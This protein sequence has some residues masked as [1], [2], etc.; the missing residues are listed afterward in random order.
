MEKQ[1][2]DIELIDA[3]LIGSLNEKEFISFEQQLSNDPELQRRVDTQKT[4]VTELKVNAFNDDVKSYL[5][6]NK[7]TK[8]IQF[9][10]WRLIGIAASV[11]ILISTVYLL[12][13]KES[14]SD[15]YYE[16][17]PDLISTRAPTQNSD[18]MF[19][20]NKK[21]YET[22]IGLF[23]KQD[24]LTDSENFYLG[25]S[26]LSVEK[27]DQAEIIFTKLL[28]TER[29]PLAQWYLSLSYIKSGEESKAVQS[30]RQIK[31]GEY[32]HAEAL[33]LLDELVD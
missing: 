33:R 25:V 26:Y 2:N 18:A 8:T 11:V 1:E 9:S 3:Y 27:L 24:I 5:S 22:A 7:G 31:E 32:K 19:H 21:E 16:P 30:L 15:Q 12:R 29:K 23:K 28:T 20:Y 10:K 13:P 14:L 6:R 4:L 17:Y